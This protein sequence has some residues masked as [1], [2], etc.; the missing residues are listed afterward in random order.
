MTAADPD[1][2]AAVRSLVSDPA[3]PVVGLGSRA[4][5]K[6]DAAL[7][8]KL[9]DWRQVGN[10]KSPDALLAG[11]QASI[12]LRQR[13]KVLRILADLRRF[14]GE[15]ADLHGEIA[16]IL[17]GIR[18]FKAAERKLK[19]SLILEPAAPAQV[20]QMCWSFRMRASD[21]A[22]AVRVARYWAVVTADPAASE[23]WCDA[24]AR[25]DHGGELLTAL[26]HAMDLGL[27]PLGWQL[28][29]GQLSRVLH[30][31]AAR[32]GLAAANDASAR[33]LTHPVLRRHLTARLEACHE[34]AS[35]LGEAAAT[36][37]SHPMGSGIRALLDG[38]IH[39]AATH[40]AASG[41]TG[42]ELPAPLMERLVSGVH[43][44]HP[45]WHVANPYF[46][47]WS[48]GPGDVASQDQW[49]TD[50]A[51]ARGIPV[52]EKLETFADWL[53]SD[54][55]ARPYLRTLVERVGVDVARV[56]D[57]GCGYGEWLRYLAEVAGVRVRNLMGVD[58]HDSRVDAARGMLSA[59]T[60]S[61]GDPRAADEIVRSNVRQADLLTFDA[62]MFRQG[63]DIDIVTLFVVTGCFDDDQL[64]E[65][66]R[67][68]AQLRP[69]YFFTTTVTSRWNL[70]NGRSNE[71][72][73]FERQG[74]HEIERHWIAS[75]PKSETE[76]SLLL[77]LR[78]WTNPSVRI[79][80]RRA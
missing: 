41:A 68:L 66:L 27:H 20:F 5:S 71:G 36:L 65:V 15:A 29:V 75:G 33:I 74:Y 55:P 24:G 8:A 45:I 80:E 76:A 22:G 1:I 14:H 54:Q 30:A 62:E 48:A 37:G 60:L 21:H 6:A 23:A 26:T 7:A 57:A 49:R 31:I 19:Q 51:V 79:Y 78:Y 56:F 72:A 73:Y 63:G 43:T 11:F 67:R 64:D 50:R 34:T 35:A 46:H 42:D 4:E 18:E 16:R 39:A 77:P 9:A 47:I 3:A 58:F 44:G 10:P 69:G 2:A 32:D 13:A 59:A 53:A 61:E 38:D 25:V 28:R 70:W 17:A 52:E 40:Y 12:D